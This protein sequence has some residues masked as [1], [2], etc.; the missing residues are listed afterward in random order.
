MATEAGPF[1]GLLS[2]AEQS[3]QIRERRPPPPQ[4]GG[5]LKS[6]PLLGPR[7][8]LTWVSGVVFNLFIKYPLG[9]SYQ[10]GPVAF[11]GPL[12]VCR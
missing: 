7:R 12:G 10:Q 2:Q 11:S 3:L 1:Q 9:S 8:G 4:L 6:G 5:M